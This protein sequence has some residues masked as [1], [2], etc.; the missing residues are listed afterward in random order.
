[1]SGKDQDSTHWTLRLYVAGNTPKSVVAFA[2]LKKIC[3]ELLAGRY[4]VEVVDLL[5]H[6]QLAKAEQIV[7]IPTLVR[8]L[9][10]PLKKIIGDLSDRQRVIL[11]LELEPDFAS[12]VLVRA[13]FDYEMQEPE[14]FR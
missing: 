7:A 9:P 12:I 11:A 2:N 4:S 5:E 8:S 6:P 14:S 1:M 3:E 10:P 13:A